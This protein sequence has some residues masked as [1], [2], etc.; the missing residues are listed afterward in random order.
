M[1]CTAGNVFFLKLYLQN[2]ATSLIHNANNTERKDLV[3]G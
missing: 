1:M 3:Q 2:G